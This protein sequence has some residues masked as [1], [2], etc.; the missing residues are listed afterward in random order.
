MGFY[1]KYS[2]PKYLRFVFLE[3]VLGASI[4][5]VNMQWERSIVR[6]SRQVVGGHPGHV[7]ARR[8]RRGGE[9]CTRA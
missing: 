3:T 5:I 8:G 4:A 9:S 2:R 1:V 6:G 7:H